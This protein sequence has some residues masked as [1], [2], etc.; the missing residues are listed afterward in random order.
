MA[1]I[2]LEKLQELLSEVDLLM[3]THHLTQNDYQKMI[4]VLELLQMRIENNKDKY[5]N[6]DRML[7]LCLLMIFQLNLKITEIL[8]NDYYRKAQ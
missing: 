6:S 2:S 4:N 5:E 8:E 1:K 3:D 7:T